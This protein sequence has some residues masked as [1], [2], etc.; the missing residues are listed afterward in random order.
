MTTTHDTPTPTAASVWDVVLDVQA[1]LRWLAGTDLGCLPDED[2]DALL[3]EV[4]EAARSVPVLQ[5]G[6]VAQVLARGIPEARGCA[7]AVAYL[8]VLVRLRRSEANARVGAAERFQP[9]T[10]LT[11]E[12]LP[13]MFPVVAEALAEGAISIDHASV[14]A[15]SL[16]HLPAAVSDVDKAHAE[17]VLVDRARESDPCLVGRYASRIEAHL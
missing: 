8:Q 10:A 16:E 15:T 2:V 13:P 6:L 9:R 1:K 7:S 14:I 4:E 11:G 3:V 5:Q 17:Q 12:K